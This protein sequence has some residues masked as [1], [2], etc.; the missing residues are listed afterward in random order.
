[1]LTYKD[2]KNLKIITKNDSELEEFFDIGHFH[3]L[4]LSNENSLKLFWFV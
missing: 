1:M 2:A 4:S 3:F